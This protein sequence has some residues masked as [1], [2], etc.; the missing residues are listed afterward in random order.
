MDNEE[1]KNI[2]R[3][4]PGGVT[5]EPSQ[6]EETLP[7][8]AYVIYTSDTHNEPVELF[9]EGF[10]VFTSQHVAVM[11]EQTNG[12]IPV[13]VVPLDRVLYTEL[14]EDIDDED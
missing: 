1:N 10:L 6:K 11:R 9:A 3:L 5:E 4:V 7:V 2:F 12:A 8:N 13:L 14:V